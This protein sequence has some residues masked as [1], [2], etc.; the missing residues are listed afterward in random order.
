[1]KTVFF[2][3]FSLLSSDSSP[4]S[5]LYGGAASK[6]IWSQAG[7]APF[8]PARS[9]SLWTELRPHHRAPG[10]S[11]GPGRESRPKMRR[12]FFRSSRAGSRHHL[13]LHQA[14]SASRPLRQP[15]KPTDERGRPFA[16]YTRCGCV[17]AYTPPPRALPVHPQPILISL[18]PPSLPAIYLYCHH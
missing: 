17:R 1:M 13:K 9:L 6:L 4:R 2:S 18:H 3:L 16:A 15:T 5:A 11:F 10:A 14:D 12:R 8:V 7:G